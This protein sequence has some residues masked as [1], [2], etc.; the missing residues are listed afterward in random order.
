MSAIRTSRRPT[1]SSQIPYARPGAKKSSW[2]IGGFLKSLIPWGSA[3]T[4]AANSDSMEEDVIATSGSPAAS[5]WD[6]GHQIEREIQAR[7]NITRTP[8]SPQRRPPATPAASSSI[9]DSSSPQKDLET[10]SAHIRGSLDRTEVERLC[11]MLKGDSTEPEPFRFL[12]SPSTPAPGTSPYHGSTNGPS[13]TFGISSA[14]PASTSTSSPR[15]TLNRNPNGVYRWQGGGSAR[16]SRSKNRYSSPAFGPSQSIPNRLI[17]K[18]TQIEIETPISDTAKRRKVTV[19]PIASSSSNSTLFNVTTLLKPATRAAGPDPSPTRVKQALPFPVSAATPATPRSSDKVNSFP[20]TSRLKVPQ[21]TQKPTVPVMPSP[22]RQTWSGASPPSRTDISTI[23]SPTKQTK[24]ANYMAELIKEVTPPKRPDL[25]NPYQTASPLGKASSAPKGRI[26]KRARATGKPA[27]PANKDEKNSDKEANTADKE[28]VCS[29]QAIIE[30]T[31][32]KGSKRSRPPAHFEKTSTSDSEAPIQQTQATAASNRSRYK[33]YVE[34]VEDEDDEDVKRA[35]KKPKSHLTGHGAS[36]L[37]RDKH[38]SSDI[39]IE[40]VEVID[41]ST[42]EKPQSVSSPPP[43]PTSATVPNTLPGRSAFTAMKSMSAPKEPMNGP[44]NAQTAQQAALK[45]PKSS[46]PT[47]TFPIT[48]EAPNSVHAHAI[49][50]AKLASKHSLPRYSFDQEAPTDAA[51]STEASMSPAPTPASFV[52]F[53][54]AAVGTKPPVADGSTWICSLCTL[55]NPQSATEECEFCETRRDRKV[56]VPPSAPPVVATTPA[57]QAFNWAAAGMK[58]PTAGDNWTCSL[59]QL[60]N[61]A[62]AT[63]KCNTC[64]NPR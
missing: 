51:A 11:A 62:S 46:L 38:A 27:A 58:A 31:V 63:E 61:P 40:E 47:F 35:T 64:E 8:P 48:V 41:G 13:F 6:R 55:S 18:D 5:L 34:T 4:D 60:S 1:R 7:E 22:L 2:S 25:S 36:T 56:I 39:T 16:A 17:L 59:C 29:T 44:T 50:E 37:A 24:A 15:K 53:N 45:A 26:G 33:A 30:A 57:V 42:P 14:V 19:E 12:A 52:P 20:S 3:D 28:K 54:W 9:F 21:V 23:P 10:V 49:L 43:P 32:P